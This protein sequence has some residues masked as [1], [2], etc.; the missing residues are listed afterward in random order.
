M[1]PRRGEPL[2]IFKLT[3]RFN[4]RKGTTISPTLHRYHDKFTIRVE[5][6][7]KLGDIAHGCRV[8][9]NWIV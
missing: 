9:M 8:W 3:R 2:Y 7:L 1:Y 5:I 6:L 4:R